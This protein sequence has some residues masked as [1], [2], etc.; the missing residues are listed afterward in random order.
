MTVQMQMFEVMYGLTDR[1]TMMAMVPYLHKEMDHLTRSGVNF[2][3]E[4]EGV[5]DVG[6][7]VHVVLRHNGPHWW[8]LT[9][10]MTVPTGSIDERGATP[11]GPNQKLPY[12]MQ[13]GSGSVDAYSALNYIY[14]KPQLVL[15]VHAKGMFS[16]GEND[17]GYQVGDR[18]HLTAFAARE[19][20]HALS[21]SGRLEGR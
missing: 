10:G 19:I 11:A 4:T 5:G 7:M 21:I 3:T 12:P 6:L 1:V 17:N 14:Q 2:T 13:L 16:T 9:P 18:F 8:I 15:G 20:T